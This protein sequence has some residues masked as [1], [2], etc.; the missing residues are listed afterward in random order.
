MGVTTVCEASQ[1]REMTHVQVMPKLAN[2]HHVNLSLPDH[3][4]FLKNELYIKL[5]ISYYKQ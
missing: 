4:F 5:F 2:C 1:V 3:L